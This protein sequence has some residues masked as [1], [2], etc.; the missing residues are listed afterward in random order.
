M[1][2]LISKTEREILDGL[3]MLRQVDAGEGLPAQ[4]VKLR[5][6][7]AQLEIEREKKQEDFARQER[8]LRHMIGLEKKRQE[9]EI[10]QAQKEAA[11]KV[12]EE[13]LSAEQ[14]RFAD[15]L[16]FNTERFEKMETYLK[17]MLADILTRLPNVSMEIRRGK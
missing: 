3:R 2:V 17:E 14:R 9:F 15:S 5:Q 12:R 16:Q 10:E 7:L 6:Q 13:N 8:E 11:L 4:I 1:I